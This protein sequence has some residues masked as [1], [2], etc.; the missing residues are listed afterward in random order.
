MAHNSNRRG[1]LT[2]RGGGNVIHARLPWLATQHFEDACTRCGE[3]LAACPEKIIAPST[4]G[5][6]SID[7]S[8]GECTFCGACAD[9]CP[10]ILFDRHWAEPWKF[11]ALI[12]AD[13]L[14]KRH[15]MCRSCED[16]CAHGAIAFIPTRGRLPSPE[17]NISHCT[18]CGAC[19]SVC[20]ETAI[21][22]RMPT[23]DAT[24]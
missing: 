7:F 13:C 12:S 5:F 11:K 18:G 9:A 20:P 1:F 16:A 19:V 17:I 3:C 14:A 10:E 22:I 15:V 23:P 21:A 24:P 4:G 6:P 8:R 2:G